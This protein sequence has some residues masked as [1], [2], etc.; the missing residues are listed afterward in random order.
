M[1]DI[2]L[3]DVESRQQLLSLHLKSMKVSADVSVDALSAKMEGYSGADIT[4][5]RLY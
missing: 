1:V 3:P 2:P 5:V 4:N